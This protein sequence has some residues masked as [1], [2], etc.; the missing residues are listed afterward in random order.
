MKWHSWGGEAE[1]GTDTVRT[2]T[3]DPDTRHYR[4][5]ILSLAS[6]QLPSWAPFQPT[7]EQCLISYLLCALR[8]R[9]WATGGTGF[10]NPSVLIYN[11]SFTP[12]GPG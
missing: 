4:K 1:G 3:Q 8:G 6:L 9:M 10:K 5:L 12:S 7:V 2:L 11:V